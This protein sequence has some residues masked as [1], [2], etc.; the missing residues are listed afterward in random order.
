MRII[1]IFLEQLLRNTELCSGEVL[2]QM[3]PRKMVSAGCFHCESCWHIFE[4]VVE[5]VL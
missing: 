3:D 1:N 4:T 2:S 5:L